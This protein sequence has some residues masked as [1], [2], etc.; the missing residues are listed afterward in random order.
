MERFDV[1]VV[2]AGPAGSTAAYTAAKAGLSVLLLERAL[3]PGD[4]NVF[5]GRV[6]AHMVRRLFSG[7]PEDMPFERFVANE[8]LC[9]M[10]DARCA[11]LDFYNSG[12]SPERA[13]SFVARRS[14]FDRWLASRAEEAGALLV[15]GTR[16]DAPFM[17]DG[18]VKGI[19]SSSDRIE[20]GC[21]IDAEGVTATIA[22]KVGMRTD[23]LPRQFKIGVKETVRLTEEHINERFSLANGEGT[24]SVFVGYPGGYLAASGAFLYTNRDTVSIGVVIE[25]SGLVSAKREVHELVENFRLHPYISRLLRGGEV[26][27]YSAH[28]IPNSVPMEREN[29]VGNGILVTGDAGG[30]FINNGYTYRGVDMAMASGHEAARAVISAHGRGSFTSE[31]LGVYYDGLCRE[32][33]MEVKR[34]EGIYSVL[35]ND[36][37]FSTYPL[38]ACDLAEGLFSVPGFG[39]KKLKVMLREEMK[40]RVGIT[41]LAMDIL[42]MYR[43][44]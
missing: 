7:I 3:S 25:P 27:E 24:A 20:A 16:V 19:L 4:K 23:I 10:D 5:G 39:K 12:A 2:G 17:E 33:L 11:C 28:M 34:F 1:I 18:Q 30:F 40:G 13:D 32:A 41:T 14:K 9:F 44:M 36:R 22:R 31:A 42:S 21:V 29:L 43:N 15:C 26:I 38:L 8:R 35:R 37:F 6:Y